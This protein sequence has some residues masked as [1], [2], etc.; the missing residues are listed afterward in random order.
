M[1]DIAALRSDVNYNY[2][3]GGAPG[4]G[5]GEHGVIKGEGKTVIIQGSDNGVY[6]HE[7]RHIGQ[8]M[9]N[10]GLRFSTRAETLNRLLNA[11]SNSFQRTNFEVDGYR[12]QFSLYRNSYPAPGGA[13]VLADINATSLKT[14]V[15][16]NGSPLY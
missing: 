4:F 6:V 12:A 15:G 14:I 2:T 9:A 5:S 10:G 1:S 13:R 11:G 16:D 3:F 7:I 8:S